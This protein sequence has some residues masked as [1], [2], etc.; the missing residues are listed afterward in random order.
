[1][2]GEHY[3]NINTEQALCG[4]AAGGIVGRMVCVRATIRTRIYDDGGAFCL[5]FANSIKS[6][7]LKIIMG[8]GGGVKG[9][10]CERL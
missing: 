7:V 8:G 4:R 6:S 9:R 5:T 3:D 10:G 2:S 1:M